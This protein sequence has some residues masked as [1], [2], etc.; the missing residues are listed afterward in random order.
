M[1]DIKYRRFDEL[2]ASLRMLTHYD[3]AT[4][5][6]LTRLDVL[7]GLEKN[8]LNQYPFAFMSSQPGNTPLHIPDRRGVVGA[9]DV[10]A[11]SEDLVTALRSLA[12]AIEHHKT[13]K[14]L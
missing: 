12:D 1:N 8:P 9:Y 7:L 6:M 13:G 4:D 5:S 10:R 2:D 3:V 14:T 11:S